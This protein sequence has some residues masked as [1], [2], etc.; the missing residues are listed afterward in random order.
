MS[1]CLDPSLVQKAT[2]CLPFNDMFTAFIYEV[3]AVQGESV[4]FHVYFISHLFLI[5]LLH[6]LQ[7]QAMP[8]GRHLGASDRLQ[9]VQRDS[10]P[11]SPLPVPHCCAVLLHRILSPS[12]LY[13]FLLQTPSHHQS[14]L[15]PKLTYCSRYKEYSCHR[16]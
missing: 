4:G 8:C 7:Q 15:A 5:F 11:S 6:R 3:Q 9:F 10:A 12:Y 14:R 13:I 2:K 1:K 16:Q